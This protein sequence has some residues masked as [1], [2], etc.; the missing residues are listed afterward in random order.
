[1]SIDIA[2]NVTPDETRVAVLESKVV[3]EL[4]VDRANK[5]DFVGDIYI[6]KVVKSIARH[7]SSIHRYWPR[8]C[9]LYACVR[10]FSRT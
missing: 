7:A 2:I 4:Y 3:T 6:G 5:K 9:C 8:P 10:S 1:M